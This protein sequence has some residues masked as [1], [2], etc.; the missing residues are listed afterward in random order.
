MKRILI[1]YNAIIAALLSLLGCVANTNT[2]AEYGTPSADF[3]VNGKV[4]SGTGQPV[5]NIA[6]V[7]RGYLGTDNDG[8]MIFEKTDST[9][10]ADN[11]DYRVKAEGAFP[12]NQ[13]CQLVFSDIDG[14]DNGAFKDTTVTVEF[15]NPVFTGGDGRWYSGE[16][17]KEVNIQL[18]PKE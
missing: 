14:A 15:I 17:C 4:S 2:I 6:V 10:T 1:V 12:K 3:I 5:H 11:G 7:M 18:R 16:T 8:R 13:T 9:G